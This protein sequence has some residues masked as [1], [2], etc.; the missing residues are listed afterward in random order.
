MQMAYHIAAHAGYDIQKAPW[1]WWLHEYAA[2]WKRTPLRKR[3]LSA[4][5]TYRQ[6]TLHAERVVPGVL[7]HV[8][9]IQAGKAAQPLDEA[10]L[11]QAENKV[12]AELLGD[13]LKSAATG[14]LM[15]GAL[16]CNALATDMQA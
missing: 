13:S 5:P 15:I 1:M 10:Q 11:A 3:F 7:A 2:G 14:A 8:A 6:R 4:A 16:I 9:K 12:V